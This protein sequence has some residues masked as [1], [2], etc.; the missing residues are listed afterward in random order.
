M[1]KIN[2]K[3]KTICVLSKILIESSSY[4]D[5]LELIDMRIVKD[6]SIYTS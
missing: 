6:R 1:V 4:C 2:S 3:W 5:V